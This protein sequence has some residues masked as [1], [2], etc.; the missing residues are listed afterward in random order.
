MCLAIP[1]QIKSLEPDGTALV[2]RDEL[3]ARIDVSLIDSPSLGDYVI[4]H[5]GYAIEVLDLEDAQARLDMFRAMADSQGR[6]D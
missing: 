5:A 3:E 4:V 2:A 6:A 1:M